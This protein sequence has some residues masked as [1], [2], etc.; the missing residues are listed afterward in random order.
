MADA[1][2]IN[3]IIFSMLWEQHYHYHRNTSL[4]RERK[5][6]LQEIKW[7]TDLQI[8]ACKNIFQHNL[9]GL[10]LGYIATN[11]ARRGWVEKINYHLSQT[12]CMENFPQH[13]N[14]YFWFL[15]SLHGDIKTW[16]GFLLSYTVGG[17]SIGHLWINFTKSQWCGALMVSFML[18]WTSCCTSSWVVDH[19]RHCDTD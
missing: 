16:T 18:A 3:M 11:E 17:E 4:G 14:K 1:A 9:P 2:F 5:L 8:K 6:M 13:H 12:M 7:I 15:N 10:H 19:L